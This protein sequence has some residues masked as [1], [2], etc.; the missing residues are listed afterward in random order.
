MSTIHT[1]PP[2]IKSHAF[3]SRLT[4]SPLEKSQ[5]LHA[6]IQV[7]SQEGYPIKNSTILIFKNNKDN[8]K[9]LQKYVTDNEGSARVIKE[10][11]T[12]LITAEYFEPMIASL[13]KIDRVKKIVLTELGMLSIFFVDELGDP[14]PGIRA[15]LLP[16]LIGEFSSWRNWP[17][18]AQEV[19]SRLMKDSIADTEEKSKMD[20]I[21]AQITKKEKLSEKEV[22]GFKDSLLKTIHGIEQLDQ[23]WEI[24]SV[25]SLLFTSINWESTSNDKGMIQF[26][27]LPARNGYRYGLLTECV[28]ELSPPFS[29]GHVQKQENGFLKI[30]SRKKIARGLSGEIEVHPGET[31]AC[32]VVVYKRTGIVGRFVFPD[33]G[34]RKSQLRLKQVISNDL[35]FDDTMDYQHY[36]LEKSLHCKA[37]GSFEINNVIGNRRKE[38]RLFGS[39]T[40]KGVRHFWFGHKEFYCPL[41]KVLNIGEIYPIQGEETPGLVRFTMQN[42]PHELVATCFAGEIP[43]EVILRVLNLHEVSGPG[44]YAMIRVDIG[45]PFMLHGL[46]GDQVNLRLKAAQTWSPIK[47]NVR[48]NF[49]EIETVST[50]ESFDLPI[51]ITRTQSCSIH[52]SFPEPVSTGVQLLFR[53]V[54]G[55][56]REK[57]LR[58]TEDASSSMNGTLF[59]PRGSC[60]IFAH[61]NTVYQQGVSYFGTGDYFV[62]NH[63]D[64]DI[65]ANRDNQADNIEEIVLEMQPGA[66]VQVLAIDRNDNEPLTN[67]GISLSP[68][69]WPGFDNYR[70][71]YESSTNN[72]GIALFEGVPPGVHLIT[73]LNKTHVFSANGGLN[74]KLVTIQGTP[75]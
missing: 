11:C 16:P 38:L 43:K 48:L 68:E 33:G 34:D 39:V 66:T 4:K 50:S 31:T 59:I 22:Q 21:I 42:E 53:G 10:D 70:W 36:K 61:T 54:D 45:K 26:H 47:Q 8:K 52:I 75:W 55:E 12:I 9:G 73:D 15:Q 7:E 2:Q 3:A 30:D 5:N 46:Q 41:G 25:F 17:E 19:F 58:P 23:S 40:L 51:H 32:Q 74:N 69:N 63:G 14:V 37:D 56:I 35:D 64:S 57:L 65:Q 29:N 28:H 1:P 60:R 27:T 62:N 67:F 18:I 71:S 24:E 72:E 44:I 20:K 6:V 13:S 49:P